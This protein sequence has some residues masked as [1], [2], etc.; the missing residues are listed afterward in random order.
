[1]NDMNSKEKMWHTLK[2][3][4]PTPHTVRG[5]IDDYLETEYKGHYVSDWTEIPTDKS[6][7]SIKVCDNHFFEIFVYYK[8]D[9]ECTLCV[10]KFK[11]EQYA[12]RAKQFHIMDDIDTYVIYCEDMDRQTFMDEFGHVYDEFY[13]LCLR[14]EYMEN[15]PDD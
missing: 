8:T 3:N 15:Y 12:H 10:I 4:D 1:M 9:I 2:C 6:L 7:Y 5:W 14:T 11:E 13:N